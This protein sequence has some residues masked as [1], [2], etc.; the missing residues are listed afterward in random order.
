LIEEDAAW[1]SGAPHSPQ[2]LF[3]GGLEAL[4]AGQ[5]A[6]SRAPHSPQNFIP[7]GF[8]CWQCAHRIRRSH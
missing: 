8:S 5:D 3:P 7:D 4:H 6:S 1:V 2:N